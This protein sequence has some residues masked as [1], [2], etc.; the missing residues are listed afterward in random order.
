MNARLLRPIGQFDP[1]RIANLQVWLDASEA[2]TLAQNS[3]GTTAV[4]ATD[5]PVAYWK[6]K[7]GTFTATQ[8]DN[9]N[10]PF[11]KPNSLN[12]RGTLFFD[13]SNDKLLV[14][15]DLPQPLTVLGVHRLNSGTSGFTAGLVGNLQNS[16]G[17]NGFIH[18]F[19]QTNASQISALVRTGGSP[20]ETGR[21]SGVGTN[22]F[23]QVTSV[24]SNLEAR[25][26]KTDLSAAAVAY[27]T[28]DTQITLGA[29]RTGESAV[30]MRAHWTAELLIYNRR[31]SAA[32]ITQLENFLSRK[33]G[34]A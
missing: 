33:W 25:V 11:Y 30:N 6:S 22:W 23:L 17:F 3:N 21:S 1:R 19:V 34:L 28:R 12:G 26:N 4:S 32:E 16:G 8:T 9:N 13:G 31:L 29:A 20:T 7:Q 24:A 18:G 5:D 2:S 27:S 15:Y 10:R 14:T